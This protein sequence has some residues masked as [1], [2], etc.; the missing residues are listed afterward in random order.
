MGMIQQFLKTYYDEILIHQKEHRCTGV[1]YEYASMLTILVKATGAKKILEVGTGIGYSAAAL[2]GGNDNVFIETID[3]DIMHLEIAKKKWKELGLSERIIDYWGKAEDILPTLQDGY[4]VIFFDANT[5][6]KKFLPEFER[7][8][9]TNGLLITTNLFLKDSKG[10][11]YLVE[12]QNEKKWST[13]LFA[14]TALSV[15][16]S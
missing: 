6:Q 4:D 14:D 2:I 11:K 8:L 5:P 10:G 15:R 1:P 3:E 9:K 12:L 13:A 7:I 16:V